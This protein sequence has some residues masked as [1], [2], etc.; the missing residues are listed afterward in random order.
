LKFVILALLIATIVSSAREQQIVIHWTTSIS[1]LKNQFGSPLFAGQT[2]NGDGCLATLG[3]YDDATE[4]FPFKGD[5]VELTQGTR[6]GDSSSGYGFTSGEFSFTAVF[7][8]HKD[9]VIIYPSNPA[10][11]LAKSQVVITDSNPQSGQPLSIRFYDSSSVTA[12]T[13]YNAVTGPGWTWPTFTSG[14][15][16]NHYFKISPAEAVRVSQWIPGYLFEDSSNDYRTSI[17]VFENNSTDD[18]ISD[19][20]EQIINQLTNSSNE[21]QSKVQT[22][23]SVIDSYK[24]NATITTNLLSFKNNIIIDYND[25]IY[26]LNSTIEI[27]KSRMLSLEN[28]LS[29]AS[30]FNDQL[31]AIVIQQD[32]D[33]SG[34]ELI[35]SALQ[36]ELESVDVNATEVTNSIDTTSQSRALEE[37]IIAS[38]LYIAQL[39]NEIE[40]VSAE[41]DL[42]R[43][44]NLE[45]NSTI[46]YLPIEG[47]I[48]S[49]DTKWV[50][51]TSR[52]LPYYYDSA[53]SSWI[54]G[55][56]INNHRMIYNYLKKEWSILK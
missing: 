34:L 43:K 33:V 36:L 21:L 22:Q 17:R 2:S 45:L 50:Y 38:D 54:Y 56:I 26:G 55:T 25:T 37:Y 9:D 29:S 15:P 18:L 39:D 16:V 46:S 11:Y 49:T 10:A 44:V 27:L 5:W 32:N 51:M 52:T 3:Y 30:V 28:S 24:L 6:V 35:I 1:T 47:W 23:Q 4:E 41:R 40:E 53:S 7:T 19:H 13:R 42:Y 31:T 20:A 14:V 48:Y 8:K 12:S